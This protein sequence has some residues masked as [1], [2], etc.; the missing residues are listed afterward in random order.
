MKLTSNIEENNRINYEG[1]DI[2]LNLYFDNVLRALELRDDSDFSDYEKIIIW[3]DMFIIDEEIIEEFKNDKYSKSDL[4]FILEE[5]FSVIIDSKDDRKEGTN[6]SEGDEDVK[7]FCFIQ[8]G[9]YIYSSFK[10]SYGIDLIDEQGKLNWFK[11][12]SLLKGLPDKSKFKEVVGIR[13]SK[14]PKRTKYN[15]E[16]IKRIKELKLLYAL[17]QSDE[18]VKKKAKT[19]NDK[20]SAIGG[21][22]VKKVGVK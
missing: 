8:D 12:I 7:L 2:E 3:L 18:E 10:A 19:L 15:H 20:F 21:A 14:I 1:R 13:S 17:R 11:F 6:N 22:L 16:E 9:E 5:I 4:V